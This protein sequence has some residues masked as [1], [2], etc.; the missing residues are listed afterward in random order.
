MPRTAKSNGVPPFVQILA[1][2]RVNEPVTPDAINAFIGIG[3][4]AAK[5]ISLLKSQAKFEF[6]VQKDGRK[7]KTYTLVK[8]PADAEVWRNMQP[9]QKKT[10]APKTPK[11]KAPK[12]VKLSTIVKKVNKEFVAKKSAPVEKKVAAKKSDA[13]IRAANLAK[14]KSVGKKFNRVIKSEEPAEVFG[15]SGSVGSIESDWDSFEGLDL[16]VLL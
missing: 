15:T 5:W 8:E 4:Y 10:P 3:D 7:V 9:K 2:L 14:L 11:A 6:T 12:T 1:I 13:E 16:S